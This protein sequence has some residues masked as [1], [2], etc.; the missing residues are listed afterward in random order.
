MMEKS[1]INNISK[2]SEIE[3]NASIQ[4]LEQIGVE[5]VPSKPN[6][7]ADS[8]KASENGE[9]VIDISEIEILDFSYIDH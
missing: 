2:I 6:F 7:E 4:L 3:S 8:V 9:K 5:Q 1:D